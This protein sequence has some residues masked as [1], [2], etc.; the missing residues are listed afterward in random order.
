MKLRAETTKTYFNDHYGHGQEKQQN[1][2]YTIKF[3]I[4]DNEVIRC[5]Q[6]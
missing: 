2:K 6:L 1:P 5:K 4:K 3:V